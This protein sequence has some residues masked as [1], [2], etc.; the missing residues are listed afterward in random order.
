MNNIKIITSIIAFL[1][2]ALC[3]ISCGADSRKKETS[4]YN[5]CIG[6]ILNLATDSMVCVYNGEVIPARIGARYYSGKPYLFILYLSAEQCS[7][8][9]LKQFYNWDS[10]MDF[11][12]RDRLGYCFIVQPDGKYS[13][14]VLKDALNENYFSS[15]VFLDTEQAFE[16]VNKDLLIHVGSQAGFFIDSSGSVL[17]AGNPYKEDALINGIKRYMIQNNH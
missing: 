12:E 15:P 4:S 2:L 17:M 6:K 14:D 7:I 11:L 9:N 5:K 3:M 10:M 16:Q 8:C 13:L 1:L